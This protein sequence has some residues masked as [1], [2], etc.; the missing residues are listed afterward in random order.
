MNITKNIFKGSLII[1]FVIIP[2]LLIIFNMFFDVFGYILFVN[3]KNNVKIKNLLEK[4]KYNTQNLKIIFVDSEPQDDDK[5]KLIYSNFEIKEC[6]I[7]S[8]SEL[9]KY[10]EEEGIDLYK[11][12]TWINYIYV[13]VIAIVIFLRKLLENASLFSKFEQSDN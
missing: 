4:E 11:T 12:I 7:T 10:I 2:V 1:F 8:E 6:L 3:D 5:V 13:I 9:I